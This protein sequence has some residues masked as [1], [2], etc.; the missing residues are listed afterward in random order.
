MDII[1]HPLYKKAKYKF[2]FSRWI[3]IIWNAFMAVSFLVSAN[4]SNESSSFKMIFFSL[5][6][7]MTLFLL[8]V[9]PKG[10]FEDSYSCE[11]I[12]KEIKKQ[13]IS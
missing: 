8:I 13:M 6:T 12:K 9:M 5:N 1:N 10:T 7:A 2:Y 3:W 11:E 4:V